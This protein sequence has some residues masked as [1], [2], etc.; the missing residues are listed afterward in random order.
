[1]DSMT[2]T[3]FSNGSLVG[4]GDEDTQ[5]PILLTENAQPGQNFLI[6]VRLDNAPV[7]TKMYQSRL[8]LEAAPNRPDPNILREEIL[9]VRPIAA[10]FPDGK[11]EREAQ[12]DASLKAIDFAALDRGDQSAF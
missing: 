5:Q 1:N 9:S 3:V 10:A 12:I 8:N 4:R 6:A 2:I 11:A 7:G